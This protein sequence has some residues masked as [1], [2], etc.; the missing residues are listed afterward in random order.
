MARCTTR[1]VVTA[2]LALTCHPSTSAGAVHRIEARAERQAP[3]VLALSFVLTG[4][5]VQLRIPQASTPRRG[6]RL[7]EHTCFEAFVVMPGSAGY[8]ELNLA[9]SGAWALHA[10]AAYRDGGPIADEGAD[11]HITVRHL[12][13]RLALDAVVA[14]ARLAPAYAT[15]PLRL[16]LAAVVETEEGALSYWALHHPPGRPDFHH[17]DAFVLALGPPPLRTGARA[18]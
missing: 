1:E 2:S 8:H 11:P 10:F 6:E 9:P 12:G 4:D 7:W 14:L 3:D 18:P 5:L 16:A 17:A 15:A 13:D